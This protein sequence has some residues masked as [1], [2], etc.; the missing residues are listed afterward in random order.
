MYHTTIFKFNFRRI[1]GSFLLC[2]FCCLFVFVPCIGS[3]D[4]NKIEKGNNKKEEIHVDLKK[5]YSHKRHKG[6]FERMGIS[7]QDCHS[8][9]IKSENTGGLPKIVKKPF[10]NPPRMICHQCHL[11]KITLPRPNQC[12]ACHTDVA[13]VKPKDH[14]LNWSTR[15]GRFAQK[16][17][18]A[19]NKC[20][21]DSRCSE[22]HLHRDPIKALVH[23]AGF[24]L[25]HSIQARAKPE[26]CVTCHRSSGFCMDCHEGR[27]R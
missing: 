12:T 1:N 2:F 26:S 23:R 10:L 20:H 16:D 5:V 15:H 22:C 4:K 11:G 24:R 7:C 17:R 13:T 27:K 9:A 25:S 8:F 19:C 6:T 3:V 14:T 18:D 21:N